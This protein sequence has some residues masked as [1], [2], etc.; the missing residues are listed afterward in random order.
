MKKIVILAAG[1][2]SRM[3]S[4]LP[5]AL[6][7]INGKPMIEYLIK[8]IKKSGIDDEPIIVVSPDNEESIKKALAKYKCKYAIQKEQL[9]TGNALLCAK[10]AIG[11]NV[12][13]VLCFYGDHPFFKPATIKRIAHSHS[14]AI[15]MMTTGV[16]DFIGWRKNFYHW[17]RVLRN[18]GN[19]KE[20]VEFKDADE[21]IKKIREV[22]PAIYCFATK[23]LWQN[24]KKLNNNNAQNEY[25]LTDLIKFAFKQGLNIGSFPIDAEEAIGVN[26][27]EELKVAESLSSVV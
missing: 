23:W 3:N 25:H 6:M 18:Y 17:G 12:N 16:K 15:T 19:I 8:V 24:I 11:K 13:Y 14:G 22:N 20:I 27:K 9:G 2:G 26:S 5:K 1:K 10:K 7:P 21:K 4:N